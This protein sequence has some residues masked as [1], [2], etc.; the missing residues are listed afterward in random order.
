[1]SRMKKV[2]LTLFLLIMLPFFAQCKIE[3]KNSA[4]VGEK[5]T[6]TAAGSAAQCTECHLWVT[7]GD[8]VSI[9]GDN[10][11]KSAT[12]T[13]RSAGRHTISL[14]ILTPQGLAQCSKSMDA[15]SAPTAVKAGSTTSKML[16][17]A[18]P[19]AETP[20]TLEKPVCD[21]PATNFKEVKFDAATV[22]LFPEIESSSF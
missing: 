6:L 10:K 9:D 21:V 2:F 20:V 14:A 17:S 4:N 16:S 1:M 19:D 8:G 7:V 22:T 15:V 18:I 5:V 13:F 12:F 11:L 3:G